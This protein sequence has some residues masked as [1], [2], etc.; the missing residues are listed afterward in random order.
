[1]FLWVDELC[2]EKCTCSVCTEAKCVR[3]KKQLQP[4]CRGNAVVLSAR[5]V[6]MESCALLQNVYEMVDGKYDSALA[7][8]G[9]MRAGTGDA[10][11][12]PSRFPLGSILLCGLA[13][14]RGGGHPDSAGAL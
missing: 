5:I 1:M 7:L 10:V 4:S 2:R 12:G 8:L 6:T 11:S 13:C 3:A 14:A 9:H